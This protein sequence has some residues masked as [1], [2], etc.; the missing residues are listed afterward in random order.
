MP[1]MAFSLQV[2]L[3]AGQCS[4]SMCSPAFADRW[5]FEV[6]TW[7]LQLGVKKIEGHT[8]VARHLNVGL[9]GECPVWGKYY[10][11]L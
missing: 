4:A 3:K 7:Q 11:I 1:Y 6:S 2:D 9:N 5:Q 10:D 8:I